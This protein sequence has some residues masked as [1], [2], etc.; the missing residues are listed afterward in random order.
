[1][2]VKIVDVSDGMLSIRG[3]Y[4]TLDFGFNDTPAI[5]H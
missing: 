2:K 3:W 1:M 5:F 4:I